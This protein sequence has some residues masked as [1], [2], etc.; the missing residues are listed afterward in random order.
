VCC[1]TKRLVEIACLPD[2]RYLA[3]AQ[4]HPPASVRR[5]QERDLHVL[6]AMRDGLSPAQSDLFWA[7]LPFVA[8]FQSDPLLTMSDED[9]A[10][11]AA[12]L[13]ATYE[14]AG[15]G[16]IYDHRPQSLLAQ[17]FVTDLKA[18]L[19]TL[20]SRIDPEAARTL[21]R[22]AVVVLRHLEQGVRKARKAV[23]EGPATALAIIGRV[24]AAVARDQAARGEE[25]L[26]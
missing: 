21:E 20:A 18:F 16:V 3:S 8:G 25:V 5:Q 9:V 10:D 2:C 17:R 11:G 26:L 14:T 12:A 4:A 7:V 1:G 22:D 24:V 19:A 13:A 6:M 23:D 15:R